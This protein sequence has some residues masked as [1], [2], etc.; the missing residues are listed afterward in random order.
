[1]NEYSDSGLRTLA[2]WPALVSSLVSVRSTGKML[3]KHM[4]NETLL[5]MYTFLGDLKERAT[6]EGD[7]VV[8]AIPDGTWSLVR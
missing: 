8:S 2:S 6:N 4:A 3:N 5:A 7:E 1:M